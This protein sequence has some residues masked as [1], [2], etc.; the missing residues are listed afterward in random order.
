[1]PSKGNADCGYKEDEMDLKS[2]E[3]QDLES[4]YL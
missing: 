4:E 2:T 1:M 3:N